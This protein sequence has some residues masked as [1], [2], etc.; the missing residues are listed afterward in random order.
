MIQR[1]ATAILGAQALAVVLSYVLA[2]HLIIAG[3]AAA[4]RA[5]ADAGPQALLDPHVFCV[6]DAKQGSPD[7]GPPPNP[8][9]GNPCCTLA[10]SGAALLTPAAFVIVAYAASV[11]TL[12][13]GAR[14]LGHPPSIAPPGSGRGPR[15]P[16][17]A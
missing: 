11:A 3:L 10:C 14:D 17:F 9:H 13:H 2:L 12:A 4:T 8:D 1:G 6:V 7:G 16:P 15:A 5:P